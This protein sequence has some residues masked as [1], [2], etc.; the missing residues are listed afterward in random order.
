MAVGDLR[1]GVTGWRRR[2]VGRAIRGVVVVVVLGGEEG[3][4]R[5]EITG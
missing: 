4:E 3:R 2:L 1:G 5:E